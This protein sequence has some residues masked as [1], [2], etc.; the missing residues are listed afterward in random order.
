MKL[1]HGKTFQ[2]PALLTIDVDDRNQIFAHT[3]IDDSILITVMDRRNGNVNQ[4]MFSKCYDNYVCL[5]AHPT[6]ACFVLEGCPE[7]KVIRNYCIHSGECQIVH[8]GSVPIRMC[9]GPAGSILVLSFKEPNIHDTM[10]LS[11]LNW[12]FEQHEQVLVPVQSFA[13]K[14]RLLGMNYVGQLDILVCIYENDGVEAVR[15]DSELSAIWKLS[16]VVDGLPVKPDSITSDTDGNTYIGDGPRSRIIKID[17]FTGDVIAVLQ[18]G[19]ENQMQ[20]RS[21]FW[22]KNEPSL[23]VVRGDKISTF[24]TPQLD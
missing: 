17:S 20:M 9:H 6:N 14:K 22:S 8:S 11:R 5:I 7:C 10:E 19:E 13:I 15:L 3:A 12:E 4:Q 24:Y 2:L 18:L 23:T 21:L 1:C 16:G